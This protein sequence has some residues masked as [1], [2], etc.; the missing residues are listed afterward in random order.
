V[1]E[2]PPAARRVGKRSIVGVAA[3]EVTVVATVGDAIG[4]SE[5]RLR[6]IDVNKVPAGSKSTSRL[7]GNEEEAIGGENDGGVER[8]AVSGKG[9]K[10]RIVGRLDRNGSR[11]WDGS[12]RTRERR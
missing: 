2:K 3:K 11:G 7:V 5:T 4:G 8:G 6:E 10:R 12:G 9:W 1:P